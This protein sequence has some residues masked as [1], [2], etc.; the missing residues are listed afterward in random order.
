M[1]VTQLPNGL[2]QRRTDWAR[3]VG[4]GAVIFG[5]I[6]SGERDPARPLQPVLGALTLVFI[7]FMWNAKVAKGD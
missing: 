4:G 3:L 1:Q 2:D 5:R 7:L 6:P